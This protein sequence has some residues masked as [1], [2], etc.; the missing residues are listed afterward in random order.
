ME[1]EKT[2]YQNWKRHI[3]KNKTMF[4]EYPWAGSGEHF[5]TALYI[6][7]NG[8]R[9]VTGRINRDF[10]NENK[11]AVYTAYDW[12]GNIVFQ[13]IKD[14]PTLKKEFIKQGKELSITIPKNPQHEKQKEVDKKAHDREMDL[15]EIREQ[16]E[17]KEQDKGIER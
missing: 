3:N 7:D 16:K 10:D 13:D 1:T 6:D 4:M 17:S 11:K 2:N 12:Q 8:K 15:K 9:M 5:I 14:L